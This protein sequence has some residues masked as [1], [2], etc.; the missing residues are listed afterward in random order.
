MNEEFN[1]EAYVPVE[2]DREADDIMQGIPLATDEQVARL[3][4]ELEAYRKADEALALSKQAEE[5]E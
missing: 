4:E 5:E 3:S 1:E 2:M